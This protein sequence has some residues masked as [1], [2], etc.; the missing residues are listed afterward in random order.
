MLLAVSEAHL[1]VTSLRSAIST[2]LW[3]T[4]EGDGHM[5]AHMVHVCFAE[6]GSAAQAIAIASA[7]ALAAGG[8][9]GVAIARAFA[10]AIGIYSCPGVKP[11]LAC[12]YT[13]I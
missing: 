11:V 2:A 13:H 9:E 10:V 12:E 5:T 1:D 8:S 6:G 3:L 4:A 7:H